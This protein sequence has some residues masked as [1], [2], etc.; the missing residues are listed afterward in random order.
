MAFGL[1]KDYRGY[2]LLTMF[3]S[4]YDLPDNFDVVCFSHLRWDFVFQRPQHLMTRFSSSHRVFFLEEPIFHDGP[5]FL[6]IIEK[7]PSL[8]VGRPR[9]TNGTAAEDVRNIVAEQLEK[10]L[11]QKGWSRYIAWFYTP[12]MIDLAVNL[13]PIA[14]VYD[15]MDELSA[16]RGAPPE[17]CDRE[18][19]L[20]ASA[21]LVFTGGQSLYESKSSKHSSV[22]AFPSS[23]DV[24]HFASALN[25]ASGARQQADIKR[26]RVGFVGV[27]DERLDIELLAKTA[28]I[29]PDW[30]FVM[31]GPVVKI[32]ENDLPRLD[33]IHY[34]GMQAY[35]DLPSFLADWDVAMMPFAMNES[36]RFIS[37]T[38]TPEYLAAGLPVVSTPIRDVVR[39]YGEMGLVHIA[40]T[41][42]KFA[43]AILAAADESADERMTKVEEILSKNSWDRTYRK[44]AEL[45]ETAV[46]AK[47]VGQAVAA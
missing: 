23:V 41:P 44:M 46:E 25:A 3:M 11:A 45:I 18:Q 19:Q 9:I 1:R 21:D 6:E 31:I 8:W 16:F 42:E 34:L 32:S 2:S 22:H 43:A 26:P 36:T 28:E 17:L 37:P 20:M 14:T 15:C 47:A 7:R 30:S 5:N 10:E 29:L 35:D 40:E 13:S 33:N 38:K 24:E 39:P 12:M 27:I 4:N